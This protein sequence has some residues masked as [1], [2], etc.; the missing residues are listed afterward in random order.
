[1]ASS[2]TCQTGQKGHLLFVSE[3][4]TIRHYLA[5]TER[6]VL[7]ESARDVVNAVWE[8]FK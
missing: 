2:T 7:Q 3:S 6:S 8:H 5:S 4:E 1:M